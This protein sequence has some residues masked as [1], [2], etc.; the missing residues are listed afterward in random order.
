MIKFITF[1][2]PDGSGKTTA[3][4]GLKK[5]L[6]KNILNEEYIF[7]REPGGKENPEAEKIRHI[8]L[9]KE[10][11]ID[12]KSEALLY[13]SA[14][15]LHLE[16]T[17]WPALQKNKI[18]FCDRYIDSSLAYQG[19]GRQLGIEWVKNIN[20][21]AT[22]NTW[23]DLTILFD[24]PPKTAMK[25]ADERAPKDRLELAGE[26]FHKRVYEGYKEVSK[27]FPKRIKIIDATQSKEKVLEDVIKIILKAIK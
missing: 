24:I 22:D 3:L 26:N 11:N 12:S 20:E 25:R 19:S 18:V 8:I 9:D 14:R 17:V 15:R 1:E 4:E 23:P 7:T 2:G 13:A 21:I 10:N 27:L 16:Q 5:Y 6:E